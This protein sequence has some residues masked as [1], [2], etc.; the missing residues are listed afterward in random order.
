M[1]GGRPRRPKGDDEVRR[2]LSA[3][4]AAGGVVLPRPLLLEVAP[5]FLLAEEV[6]GER[7]RAEESEKLPSLKCEAA[8]EAAAAD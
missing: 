2:F 5:D 8:W 6:A 7:E 1:R 3:A 4:A